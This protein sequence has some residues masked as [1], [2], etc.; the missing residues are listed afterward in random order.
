MADTSCSGPPAAV[1]AAVLL[2][3][4]CGAGGQQQPETPDPPPDLRGTTVMLLPVQRAAGL[5]T[6]AVDAELAYWLA[7]RA[8]FVEWLPPA[9]LERVAAGSPALDLRLRRPA[10]AGVAWDET[11]RLR[12]PFYGD[13]RR[14]GALADARLALLP[15]MIRFPV[16]DSTAAGAETAA[17]DDTTAA[18]G[19]TTT[20]A[21]DT[22]GAAV[23]VVIEAALIDT[24]GGTV[25]WHGVVSDAPSAHNPA[26]AA[27][28]AAQALARRLFP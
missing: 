5:D 16:T 4:A 18:A 19:D 23:S 26:V 11:K 27:A 22:G 10:A 13:L 20:A 2:T 6:A 12:E 15:I 3:A 9:R 14:L 8:P 7:D 28:T 25:L 1:L 21:R 24:F 17:V